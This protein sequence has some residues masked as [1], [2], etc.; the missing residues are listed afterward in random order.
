MI[1]EAVFYHCTISPILKVL[2]RLVSKIYATG[3]RVLVICQNEAQL[4]EADEV[5]WTFSTKEF[6]PHA[7]SQGM[8]VSEQPIL[9]SLDGQNLNNANVVV[10]LTNKEIELTSG[11]E[12]S[13]YM[14][15]GNPDESEVGVPMSLYSKYKSS[16]VSAVLWRQDEAG[17]WQQDT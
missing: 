6:L 2:P 1:T 12:K 11:F 16:G 4:K 9:L 15:Y 10:T 3:V 14:F 7:T 8:Q 17:Q 5:L 13:L